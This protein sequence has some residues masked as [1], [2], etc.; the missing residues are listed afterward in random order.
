M[1]ALPILAK[2]AIFIDDT[3][4]LTPQ[5]LRMRGRRLVS[6]YGCQILYIDHLHEIIDPAHRGDEQKDAKAA[7]I[8]AKW[9]A[10]VL[11]VP[12]VALA[13]LNREFEKEKGRRTPRMSDLR[14]HGANEQVA[15]FIGIIH[16]D[17]KR[18]EENN[19]DYDE[20]SDVWL[21]TL[22]VCK[23][24][25][26]PTGPVQFVFDRPTMR[27]EDATFNTGNYA[28]GAKRK[29]QEEL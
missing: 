16:R 22:E 24:R 4:A 2:A 27:Y 20:N 1:D 12:V 28:S 23:Q 6:R 15:D 21:N 3:P 7:V 14:G 8:A 18:E 9:L 10:K 5:A 26:G 29:E 25:N 13:Q 11:R 19:A 17:H